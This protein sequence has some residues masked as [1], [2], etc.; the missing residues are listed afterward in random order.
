[1]KLG[2]RPSL[3][4]TVI[5]RDEA[6]TRFCGIRVD[7]KEFRFVSVKDGMDAFKQS[8]LSAVD[9]RVHKRRV[10]REKL[11]RLLVDNRG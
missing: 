7:H 9:E 1:M 2:V 10:K 8:A 5:L 4:A 11:R 6:Q 3:E